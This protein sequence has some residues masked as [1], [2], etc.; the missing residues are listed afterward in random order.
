MKVLQALVGYLAVIALPF[1]PFA[2]ASPLAAI[3]Y[4][5]YVN[6]T[7]SHIDSD[8]MEHVLGSIVETCHTLTY[9]SAY[10]NTTQNYSDS[11]LMKHI[12]GDIE[13]RQAAIIIPAVGFIITLLATVALSVIWI[14]GDNPVRGNDVAFLLRAL[15]FKKKTFARD[16]RSLPKRLSTRPFRS[17]QNSTGLFATLPIPSGLMELRA[18]TGV[19]PIT[20]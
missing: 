19:T 6:T 4:D 9:H 11:A 15:D 16:V 18:R 1:H 8:L 3:Y 10:A 12:P 17:I 20:N 13:A 2:F 7:Q 5:G 14:K